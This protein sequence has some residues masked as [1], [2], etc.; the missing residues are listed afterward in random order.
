MNSFFRRLRTRRLAFTFTILA[1]LSAG[2]VIG[3]VVANGVHGQTKVNSSDAAS[4][5]FHRR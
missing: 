3:S 5:R 2:I 4:S 1:T